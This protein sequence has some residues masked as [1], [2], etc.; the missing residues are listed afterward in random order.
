MNL[1]YRLFVLC[2][3]IFL[4]AMYFSDEISAKKLQMQYS[5]FIDDYKKYAN[6]KLGFDSVFLDEVFKN[7]S[8]IYGLYKQVETKRKNDILNANN[9]DIL[10]NAD[11]VKK[12]QAIVKLGD[13]AQKLNYEN[14]KLL[15]KYSDAYANKEKLQQAQTELELAKLKMDNEFSL[16]ERQKKLWAQE[17][18]SKNDIDQRELSYKNAKSNFNANKLRIND[19]KKQID[20]QSEQTKRTA[21]I[22]STSMNDYIIKSEIDGKIYSLTK[23][24][25][26]MVNTQTPIAVIGD[27]SKFYV[28]L[29]VDEYDISKL[30]NGQKVLLTMDSY[31]GEVF[32]ATISKM[33]SMMNERSKSFKV[34]AIFTKQPQNLYPNLTTEANIIIEVKEKAITIPRNYLIGND[35]VLLAKQEKRKVTIGLKDYEKVEILSGI[36]TKDQLFKPAQ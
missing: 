12:G 22:S 2:G 3:V 13:D 18:G 25:G 31:K 1:V 4:V 30:V 35:L 17:I 24:K 19:L 23:E 11:I 26:E 21:S 5:F 9:I 27:A 6:K 29:Q 15:A 32:E 34:E 14:A 16:L 7:S 33:Y 20:F 8:G 36:T 28:E 10:L